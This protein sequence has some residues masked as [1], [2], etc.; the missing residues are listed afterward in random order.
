MPCALRA[1]ARY[2][3]SGIAPPRGQGRARVG[4]EPRL[5]LLRPAGIREHRVIRPLPEAL[6]RF[7]EPSDDSTSYLQSVRPLLPQS[8]GAPGLC[9]I[10]ARPRAFART[11]WPDRQ[12]SRPY[13]SCPELP[14]PMQ[15][16]AEPRQGQ[17]PEGIHLR[18]HTGQAVAVV[19]LE[20][21]PDSII[22][23]KATDPVL[24]RYDGMDENARAAY[25][26][27]P[28]LGATALLG[29]NHRDRD[30]P[31]APVRLGQRRR[32]EGFLVRR[33]LCGLVIEFRGAGAAGEPWRHERQPPKS[34]DPEVSHHIR[35]RG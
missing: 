9:P 33:K 20:L 19:V 21:D 18:D 5:P 3:F 31:R 26:Y 2:D 25:L 27:E 7:R 13:G 4:D 10:R 28:R 12:S 23:I 11:T 17:G 6:R 30:L 24:H 14:G 16:D 29:G 35:L 22:A 32:R 8:A 34:D 15:V 1:P